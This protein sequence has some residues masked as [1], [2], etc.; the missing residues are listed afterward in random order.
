MFLTCS[1]WTSSISTLFSSDVAGHT[2]DLGFVLRIIGLATI[3]M[4]TGVAYVTV[5]L[6]GVFIALVAEQWL[7]KTY[8]GAERSRV[9]FYPYGWIPVVG[10]RFIARL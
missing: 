8:L 5:L 6:G 7:L 3:L 10:Q 4:A 9:V 1:V 2:D